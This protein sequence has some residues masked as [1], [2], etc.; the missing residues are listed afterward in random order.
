MKLA[1]IFGNPGRHGNNQQVR[2]AGDDKQ[3]QRIHWKPQPNTG[4]KMGY[5][6]SKVFPR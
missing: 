6:E 3:S 5:L 2:S 4:M 1:T